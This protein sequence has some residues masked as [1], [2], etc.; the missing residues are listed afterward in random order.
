MHKVVIF[1]LGPDSG[2]DVLAAVGRL[3]GV[4]QACHLSRDSRNLTARR[5]CYA[6]LVEGVEAEDIR[7]AI[8]AVD[9]VTDAS[10]PP[11]RRAN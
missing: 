1:T 11:V 7:R 6:E 8:N 2:D 9:G 10:I 4:V 3:S 5:I